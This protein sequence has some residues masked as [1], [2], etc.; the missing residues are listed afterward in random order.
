MEI[1]KNFLEE[2]SLHLKVG[3]AKTS[4]KIASDYPTLVI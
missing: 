3:I 2:S 1:E 4:L